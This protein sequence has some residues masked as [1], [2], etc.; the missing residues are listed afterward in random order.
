MCRLC[1][2][3]YAC[4]IDTHAHTN[5]CPHAHYVC[6]LPR[7]AIKVI[8]SLLSY[9]SSCFALPKDRQFVYLDTVHTPR[10]IELYK[11]PRHVLRSATY[12]GLM[13]AVTFSLEGH[14]VVHC[15]WSWFPLLR[16]IVFA[17]SLLR[18][19]RRLVHDLVLVVHHIVG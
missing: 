11:Y 10:G 17:A 8:R 12:L 1:I 2:H 16:Q 15:K 4:R 3:M 7:D 18:R 6:Q 9:Y 13:A 14:R 19:W 5:T